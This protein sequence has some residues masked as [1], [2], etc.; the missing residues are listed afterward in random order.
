MYGAGASSWH[1]E[2]NSTAATTNVSWYEADSNPT[3]YYWAGMDYGGSNESDSGYF[4]NMD[5]ALI[6]ENVDLTGADAAFMDISVMCSAAYFELYLAEQYSVVERW[7]YEDS[8][9]IEVWSD[10]NGWESVFFNGGWDN[11]RYFRILYQGVDPEYNTCLL[12]TSPSP[13]D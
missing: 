9:G 7:L 12:Y 3:N 11:E 13:R 8:C 1:I 6:L 2:T 5:E 4:N 10:G